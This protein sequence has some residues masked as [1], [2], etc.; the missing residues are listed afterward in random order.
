MNTPRPELPVKFIPPDKDGRVRAP[1]DSIRDRMRVEDIPMT[2]QA[3]FLAPGTL[4]RDV[5]HGAI[6]IDTKDIVPDEEPKTLKDLQSRPAA[7]RILTIVD[8][9]PVEGY[10]LDCRMVEIIRVEPSVDF[11]QDA[12][13][14]VGFEE[15]KAQ[16]GSEYP[17]A[18]MF[19]VD[20]VLRYV[21]DTK[22]RNE[23]YQLMA[24]VDEK[25]AQLRSEELEEN[26]QRI[27]REIVRLT[28]ILERLYE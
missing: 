17:L 28:R 24:M 13:S 18:T 23:M 1:L 3:V 21:G 5:S 16:Y 10:I 22:Y 6:F 14:E 7:M 11:G 25:V 15:H 12:S 27:I 8:D 2:N 19:E 4:N 20:G 9:Q 26:P